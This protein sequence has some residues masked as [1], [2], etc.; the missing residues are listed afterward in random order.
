[1]NNKFAL[2]VATALLLKIKKQYHS[3]SLTVLLQAALLIPL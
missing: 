2:S 3:L 1:M